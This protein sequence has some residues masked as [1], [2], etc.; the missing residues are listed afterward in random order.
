MH[1]TLFLE[2]RERC[3][4]SDTTDDS[5]NLDWVNIL[6]RGGIFHC[7]M[8]F[9]KFLCAMEV[10]VNGEMI[11]GNETATKAGFKEKL[12]NQ[13]FACVARWMEVF[14]DGSK[15]NLVVQRA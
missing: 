8:E 5:D 9:I 7:R 4:Q 1:Y 6:D 3:D 14:K 10:V 11:R 12:V 2:D 13:G 15:M